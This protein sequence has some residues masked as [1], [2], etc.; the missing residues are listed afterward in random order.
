M[1][2]VGASEEHSWKKLDVKLFAQQH[3]EKHRF[4]LR[5]FQARCLMKRKVTTKSYNRNVIRDLL[6]N[7]TI[8]TSLHDRRQLRNC[9]SQRSDVR[10][11]QD[12]LAI[13]LVVAN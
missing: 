8:E 9:A 2:L 3:D 6:F 11:S 4:V 5:Q 10:S 1:C 12:D 7:E 13:L